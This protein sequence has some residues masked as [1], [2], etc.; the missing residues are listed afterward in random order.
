MSRHKIVHCKYL[1]FLCQQKLVTE[2]TLSTVPKF[3]VILTIEKQKYIPDLQVAVSGVGLLLYCESFFM[4]PR[5]LGLRSTTSYF[6]FHEILDTM[7]EIFV[8]RKAHRLLAQ[9]QN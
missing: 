6:V 8:V 9:P 3:K 2:N 4:N 7:L 1:Q 5:L